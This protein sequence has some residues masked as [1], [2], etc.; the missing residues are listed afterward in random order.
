MTPIARFILL[1]ISVPLIIVIATFAYRN[2]Q[3]VNIDFFINSYNLPLAAILL[4][5]LIV[6][7]I[8]GFMVNFFV[9]IAQKNKIRKMIKQ[10]QEMLA[11]TD[12]FKTDKK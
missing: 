8:L 3:A 6:G 4:V 7:G 1:L 2:A 12:I 11:L 5:T 10:K 9:L